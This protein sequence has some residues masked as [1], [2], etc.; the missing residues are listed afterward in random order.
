MKVV[1]LNTNAAG[2]AATACFRLHRALVELGVDSRVITLKSGGSEDPRIDSWEQKYPQFFG[3][4]NTWNRIRNKWPTLG[5]P[6]HFFSSPHS[7]FHVEAHPW[8]QE[9]DI[10]HLHWVAKFID[11]RRFFQEHKNY[12]WTLHDMQ[13]FSGGFHY[14][15]GLDIKSYRKLI[16]HNE[17]IKIQALKNIR[18][19][20]VAPSDWLCQLAKSSKVFADKGCLHI[21]NCIDT[22]IFKPGNLLEL[23]RQLG[24]PEHQKVLLFLAEN[25]DEPRK[26][27]SLLVEAL[28]SMNLKDTL[29]VAVGKSPEGLDGLPYIHIPFTTDEQRLAMIYAAADYYITPSLE[30]NLPN[31]VMESLACGTPVI[32]FHTG[33]IPEM[34]QDGFNGFICARADAAALKNGIEL[35]LSSEHLAVLSQQAEDSVRERY[36]FPIIA[37]KYKQLYQQFL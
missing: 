10:V 23:R 29:L 22:H 30:D 18:L 27:F 13:P 32:A 33:G 28:R 17:R 36:R 11:Y 15:G 34:V 6:P 37:Q 25:L 8:V 12:V 16:E 2:G 35:A 14:T 20:P 19:Q 3:W 21:P 7:V 26:G 31:T 4:K 5:K 9:A 24:W 1:H